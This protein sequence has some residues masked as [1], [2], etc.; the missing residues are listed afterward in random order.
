MPSGA[1]S[2]RPS[3]AFLSPSACRIPRTSERCPSGRRGRPAKALYGLKPVS[4]VRIPLSP[5]NSPLL[6]GSFSDAW[7][8]AAFSKH[9]PRNFGKSAHRSGTS[10]VFA[11]FLRPNSPFVI[12][13]VR[14]SGI[15]SVQYGP[16]ARIYKEWRTPDERVLLRDLAIAPR[17][18]AY[19]TYKLCS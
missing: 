5:P 10:S 15:P 4:R 3:A 13:E 16:G 19:A 9:C 14:L 11:G 17:A 12:V 6:T 2:C 18:I 7:R 1:G 8:I